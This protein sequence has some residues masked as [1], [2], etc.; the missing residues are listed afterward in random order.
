MPTQKTHINLMDPKEIEEDAVLIGLAQD[1]EGSVK[2]G[3][4]LSHDEVWG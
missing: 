2:K 3:D 4:Y 1:R